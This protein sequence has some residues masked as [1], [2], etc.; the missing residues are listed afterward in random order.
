MI[1]T[2]K[3]YDLAMAEIDRLWGAE[4]GTRESVLLNLLVDAVQQY[5][6]RAFPMP[7][8]DAVDAILFR[9]DQMGWR[10]K[11]VAA[12]FG[13]STHASEVLNR[14]RKLTVNMAVRVSKFMGIPLDQLTGDV[15]GDAEGT[16]P[17]MEREHGYRSDDQLDK[18]PE[19]CLAA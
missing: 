3:D 10:N 18:G 15:E 1:T 6:E 2:T 11:D 4:P 14:R 12:L 5:E 8:T 17:D 16:V 19:F 9:M 7:K 13:G